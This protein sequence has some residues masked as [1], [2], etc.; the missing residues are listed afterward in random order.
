[1]IDTP[2]RI[3]L[4]RNVCSSQTRTYVEPLGLENRGELRS[5]ACSLHAMAEKQ[6]GNTGKKLN[7]ISNGS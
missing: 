6:N 2:F 3:G 4:S 5:L 1:M 7:S